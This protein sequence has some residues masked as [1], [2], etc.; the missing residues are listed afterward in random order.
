MSFY[1]FAYSSHFAL[2]ISLHSSSLFSIIWYNGV[3][4]NS[5][6]WM[7]LLDEWHIYCWKLEHK[8]SDREKSKIFVEVLS[9][10]EH[11]HCDL[12]QVSNNSMLFLAFYIHTRN[13]YVLPNKTTVRTRNEALLNFWNT[14]LGMSQEMGDVTLA[15]ILTMKRQISNILFVN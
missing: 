8:T 11:H 4:A 14:L 3:C 9:S 6:F 15:E 1:S 10:F 2:I 12:S 7:K 5:D 13:K